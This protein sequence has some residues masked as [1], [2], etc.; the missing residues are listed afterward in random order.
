MLETYQTL[1]M[2]ERIE[3][4]ND[5]IAVNARKSVIETLI[6][7]TRTDRTLM[8]KAAEARRSSEFN[9]MR[10]RGKGLTVDSPKFMASPADRV[11]A[12]ILVALATRI[13]PPQF[14]TL[15]Y[16]AHLN[17]VYRD[18]SERAVEGLLLGEFNFND[19]VNVMMGV[20]A[21]KI[22]KERC[23]E[24]GVLYLCKQGAIGRNK[25]CPFCIE[26]EIGCRAKRKIRKKVEETGGADQK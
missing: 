7:E 3:L 26:F 23:G 17:A 16:V 5:L 22:L 18:W 12:S 6:P 10:P 4:V 2:L 13:E 24:C 1:S 25:A 8:Q 11:Q 9:L 20:S 21:G 19:F 14:G 15:G